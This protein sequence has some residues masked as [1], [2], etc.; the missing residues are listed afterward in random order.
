[1]LLIS[2]L[3]TL[4]Q[5]IKIY[6]LNIFIHTNQDYIIYSTVNF[7]FM[8]TFIMHPTTE[9]EKGCDASANFFF[10]HAILKVFCICCQIFAYFCTILSVFN[11]CLIFIYLIQNC[12]ST[13]EHSLRGSHGP[14]GKF[15]NNNKFKTLHYNLCCHM[16]FAHFQAWLFFKF[17]FNFYIVMH[18]CYMCIK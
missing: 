3:V 6:I 17:V 14:L 12:T 11:S 16:Y 15:Y 7:N 9:M 10:V 2:G 13:A 5:K 8:S 1:M 18:C 4:D